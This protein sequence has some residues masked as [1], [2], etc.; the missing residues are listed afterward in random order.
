[1]SDF[2]TLTC[3]NCSGKLQITSDIDR[4]ACMHCGTEH[5]VKRGS[6]VISLAPVLETLNKM[7]G[8]VD[9][10]ARD[11]QDRKQKEKISFEKDELSQA[12]ATLQSQIEAIEA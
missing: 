6:G 3:P 10:I 1:M 9:I 4:F 7:Q 2:V 8:G 12:N 5:I 11:I